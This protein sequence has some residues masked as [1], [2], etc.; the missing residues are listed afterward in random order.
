[1]QEQ[2]LSVDSFTH[3]KNQAKI[4]KEEAELAAL[5]KGEAS[6]EDD[7]EQAEEAKSDSS[8]TVKSASTWQIKRRTGSLAL[9]SL[10]PS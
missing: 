9:R 2:E 6:T 10:S 3:N 8:A 1:M 5:L 7:E 4:A